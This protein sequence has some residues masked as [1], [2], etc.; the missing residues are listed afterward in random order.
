MKR[1]PRTIIIKDNHYVLNDKEYEFYANRGIT[2][3]EYD[4]QNK[5]Q[6]NLIYIKK[7][8]ERRRSD[9][10]ISFMVGIRQ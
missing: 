7:A 3:R 9:E 2:I 6:K 4:L 5:L 1:K 10:A 8:A